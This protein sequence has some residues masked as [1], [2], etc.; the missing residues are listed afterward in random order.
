MNIGDN[1]GRWM[2]D[3]SQREVIEAQGGC[4]LVLAPPGCGKTQILAERIGEAYAQG[5]DFADM[6][7]LTFTNRAARGMAQRIHTN[8]DAQGIDELYVGNIH[9]FCSRFLF[10]NNLVP[11]ESSVIDEDDAVSILARYLDEDEYAVAANYRRRREYATVFHLAAFMHQIRHSHPRGLRMHPE[12]LT[13]DDI[14]AVRKICAIQRMAFDAEAL[15]DIYDHSDEY[16]DA[17]LSD[18]YDYGTRKIVAVL[19]RKMTMAKAYEKYKRDNRLLDFADLLLMTY[20][21]LRADT[22]HEYKRYKWLQ[23]DEVQDLNAMQMAIVDAVTAADARTVMFFGDEQQAIFSFMG[24]KVGTLDMLKQRCEGRIHRLNVNYRSPKYLLE[25]FN[26]YAGNVLG[27]DSGLLPET[28]YDPPRTGKELRIM[29]CDTYETEVRDVAQMTE[30]LLA[31]DDNGTT[32]VVVNANRDAVEVSAELEKR[33]VGHF[34]VSGTDLFASEQMKLVVAHLN[35]LDN[36]LNFLAWA[37][38]VKGVHVMAHNASARKFVRDLFDRAIVPTDFIDYPDGRTYVQDFADTYGSDDI[39]VFDTETT[40]LDVFEDDIVQIAAV[41]MRHGKIVP[42]SELS[43]FMSTDRPI[44]PK[45]G[46]IENPLLEEMSRHELLEH[47]A[48]LEIFLEYVGDSV[49]LGHNADFDYHIL[50]NNL[51]RY[52]GGVD[53]RKRC[54]RYFDSLRLVRLLEPDLKVHKLKYLLAVLGLQGSNTH[55]ADDDVFATC[56]VVNHCYAKACEVI[57]EQ[58]RFMADK[59]VG[60]RAE[61]LRK[62]Y[63]G[64]FVEARKRLYERMDD[65][66]AHTG[67]DEDMGRN[68]CRQPLVDEM[69]RFYRSAVDEEFISSVDGMEHVTAFLSDD[70]ISPDEGASLVE[71][72]SRHIM[73]INSFKEADLCG[74]GSIKERVYVT[75]VH[76]AKGLEFDNVIV[77]DAVD[78][79]YPNFYSKDNPALLAEDARKFYVAMSRAKK[80][81]FVTYSM[82]RIDYHNQIH[83][84][85]LTRFMNPLLDLFG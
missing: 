46:D 59:T 83:N 25:V 52:C 22:Q 15:V 61:I 78:G 72:L 49:L 68:V 12:C 3:G 35:L 84:L 63:G 66:R 57:A 23:V 82:T 30:A 5:I 80:R 21:A 24:A 11:A 13:S 29:G 64:L 62:N 81:L 79:R 41:R 16:R 2:P 60:E 53:L 40:G 1:R 27:I 26:R 7:C 28:S 75:T 19:L 33:G 67:N 4:H 71:Q 65:S 50:E 45:L 8:I 73:D 70:V 43:V 69:L 31:L 74:S 51:K 55:L 76:K 56:S 34:K 9:R 47:A 10:T 32:A 54:P 14:A 44:P 48:G 85:Q 36:D 18:A 58:R 6:L 77:F 17:A 39:V 42:G 38:M 37:R 20:D